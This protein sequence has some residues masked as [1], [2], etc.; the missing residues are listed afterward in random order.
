MELERMLS[1][2]GTLV[3]PNAALALAI[4][5]R[6]LDRNWDRTSRRIVKEAQ[7]RIALERAGQPVPE[8][9]LGAAH[10]GPTPG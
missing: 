6:A 7:D 5:E 10:V 2:L 9:V 1:A 3:P 4:S 8:A